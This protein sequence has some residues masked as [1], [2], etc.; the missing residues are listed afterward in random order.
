MRTVSTTEKTV[1][2]APADSTAAANRN[3]FFSAFI[4]I[5]ARNTSLAACEKYHNECA[6][7]ARGPK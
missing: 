2:A 1:T 3:S 7:L 5:V 6:N 4:K